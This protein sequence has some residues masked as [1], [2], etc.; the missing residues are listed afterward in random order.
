MLIFF[1]FRELAEAQQLLKKLSSDET[2]SYPP[3]SHDNNPGPVS[4]GLSRMSDTMTSPPPLRSQPSTAIAAHKDNIPYTRRD[5][6]RDTDRDTCDSYRDT[7]DSKVDKERQHRF[8]TSKQK[9]CDDLLLS[10][11]NEVRTCV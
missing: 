7:C 3:P 10:S 4:S 5:S 1:L 2:P 9:S 8:L 11:L 6:R